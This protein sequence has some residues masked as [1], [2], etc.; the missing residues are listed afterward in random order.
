V[1]VKDLF[2][3]QRYP[4]GD[5][6]YDVAGWT[7]PFLFGVRRVEVIEKLEGATHRASSIEAV[8]ASSTSSRV[9]LE[10]SVRSRFGIPRRLARISPK[11]VTSDKSSFPYSSVKL[12]NALI[13][14]LIPSC[15]SISL[16]RDSNSLR[17]FANSFLSRATQCVKD[18]T[19]FAEKAGT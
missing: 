16:Q 2:D 1:H 6:P 14:G 18:S 4:E 10:K 8:K 5:A 11:V 3:V 7:L 13:T 12:R 15:W 9:R 17:K 19:L